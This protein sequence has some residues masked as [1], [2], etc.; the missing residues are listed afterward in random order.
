MVEQ[1]VEQAGQSPEIT[2][3]LAENA[4]G[5]TFDALPADV[6][7]VTKHCLLDWLGVTMA[8]AQEPLTVKLADFVG[9]EGGAAQAML[10]GIGKRV[11]VGQAALVNG[12]A[13]HALDYDDVLRL[14]NGHPTA[15]VLPAVLALAEHRGA[16]G[17]ALIEAFTAGVET[18]SRAGS[19]Q[20]D[21]RYAQRWRATATV[22]DFGAAAGAAR[23]G[24]AVL[25]AVRTLGPRRAFHKA[26]HGLA[27]P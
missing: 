11:S 9:A 14:L 12:S 6:V 27:D 22:G 3:L 19:L 13:G 7:F 24:F 23:P 16:N 17:R 2:R 8:G 25:T 20:G 26:G 15:P 21:G 5:I 4:T 18:D 1:A 10:N